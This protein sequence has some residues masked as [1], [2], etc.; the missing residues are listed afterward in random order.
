PTSGEKIAD[1]LDLN[2]M[3][4]KSYDF[5]LPT[6][7]VLWQADRCSV[8]AYVSEDENSKYILQAAES[9]IK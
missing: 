7:A 1:Q 9:K 5:V 4:E 2:V 3:I 8:I 6:D